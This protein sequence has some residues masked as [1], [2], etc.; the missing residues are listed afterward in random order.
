LVDVDDSADLLDAINAYI[1]ARQRAAVIE[2]SMQPLVENIIDQRTLARARDAGDAD[3]ETQR[4]RD[5]D[6]AQVVC[7]CTTH[8]QPLPLR[9]AALGWQRDLFALA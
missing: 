5:I 9:R 3:K 1:C 6:V 2:V 8:G 4:N 7:A